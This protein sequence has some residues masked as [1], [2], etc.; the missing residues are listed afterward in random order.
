MWSSHPEEKNICR[1]VRR[2]GTVTQET[3]KND[4]SNGR[5]GKSKYYEMLHY[6]K[7]AYLQ[8]PMKEPNRTSLVQRPWNIPVC[9]LCL[10]LTLWQFSGYVQVL[11]LFC[12]IY[13]FGKIS[14]CSHLWKVLITIP[15]HPNEPGLLIKQCVWGFTQLFPAH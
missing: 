3:K 6:L 15:K 10:T 1:G 7:V 12:H 9:E 11:S 8:I 14:F 5:N 4:V 2:G 13:P